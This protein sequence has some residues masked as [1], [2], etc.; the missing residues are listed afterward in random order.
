[1]TLINVSRDC[2]VN[3]LNVT[4]S[5]D[6]MKILKSLFFF[7]NKTRAQKKK[8]EKYLNERKKISKSRQK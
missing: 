5:A 2:D 4:K 6:Y 7:L 1:M 8:N 3:I